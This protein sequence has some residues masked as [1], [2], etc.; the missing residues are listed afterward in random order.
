MA[1]KQL[2]MK[3]YKRLWIVSELYYPEMTST[4]HILTEIAE[5]LVG[6]YDLNV[7][8]GQPTY[9]ARGTRAPARET[10]N[11]VK[12]RRCLAATLNKDIL[13]FRLINLVTISLSLF[14][15]VTVN[16][17][18][19]DK[20]L[21]VTNPPLLPFLVAIACKLRRA[22]CVLLIHDIYP[23]LLVAVGKVRHDSLMTKI[24]SWGNGILYNSM[25]NILVIGRDMQALV[26]S[27]LSER[28][29]RVIVATNWAD[30]ELVKPQDRKENSL[31]G[32]LGLQDEF[33]LLYA[34]NMGYPNDIES[35][36]ESAEY[37]INKGGIHYLFLGTGAKRAWLERTVKEKQLHNVTILSGRP[38]S[39]QTIFLNACD[40]AIISLVNG[41]KGISVPSR[42]YNT[43]ASGKPIIAIAEVG[44]ELS[45][46]VEEEGIGW[47]VPPGDP[48]RLNTAIQ[49]A[50]SNKDRLIA[51]GRKS[52]QLAE[53]KYTY[54]QV[55]HIYKEMFRSIDG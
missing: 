46:V 47:V 1:E 23:D 49:Q 34:G 10:R 52:R 18:R 8:C 14:F 39:E 16:M 15:Y 29:E 2:E 24:M 44:S 38:R 19:D 26:A 51:M 17:K 37:F 42:L 25:E 41:M 48:L 22:K 12:I 55:M 27:K 11:G 21:V 35:I 36:V 40:M 43:L 13:I 54:P 20:V 3:T 31:V 32:E 9:S 33:V 30:I 53:E 6:E 45:M 50:R 28:R 5:G 7:L 4:G